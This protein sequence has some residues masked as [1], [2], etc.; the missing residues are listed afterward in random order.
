MAALPSP[1]PWQRPPCGPSWAGT[2]G[3]TWGL[4]EQ[5]TSVLSCP[6]HF[7]ATVLQ[8][9][10]E[11]PAGAAPGSI[12]PWAHCPELCLGFCICKQPG[13]RDAG[14]HGTGRGACAV[15]TGAQ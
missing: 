3:R 7:S 12:L 6:R 9:Q 4:Q 5:V 1:P 15:V 13:V 2:L 11:S 8:G 14:A 10:R